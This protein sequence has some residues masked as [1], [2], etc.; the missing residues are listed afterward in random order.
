MSGNPVFD[1]LSRFLHPKRLNA[2]LSAADKRFLSRF[3][4]TV[5]QHQSEPD[6]TTT[7]AAANVGMSRMHLNRRLRELTGQSTHEYILGM[8]LEAARKLLPKPLPVARIARSVGFKSDSHF[9]QAFRKE[10]GAPPTV[11]RT[12][13]PL[14]RQPTGRKPSGK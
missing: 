7:A 9:A 14:A 10:F 1:A 13:H 3:R 4:A 6:F 5:T 2:P 11:Y 8:R 12:Q